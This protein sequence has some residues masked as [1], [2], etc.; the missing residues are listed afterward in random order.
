MVNGQRLSSRGFDTKERAAAWRT[1]KLERPIPDVIKSI[2]AAASSMK[3]MTE[4]HYSPVQLAK[5]WG[6]SARFVRELFRDEHGVIFIDRAEQMHKRGYLTMRIPESV[7]GLVYTRRT[8]R[9][10]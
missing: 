7:A 9:A 2:W 3:T 10:A 5:L 8:S 1:A 6:F 4:Q